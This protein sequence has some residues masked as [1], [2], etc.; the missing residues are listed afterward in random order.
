M[1]FRNFI[2]YCAICG[3]WAAFL[4]WALAEV[5]GVFPP[6]ESKTDAVIRASVIGALV[7]L[8]VASTIGMLDA[9]LN[10]VGF[11]RL[12]RAGVCLGVGLVGGAAGACVG[13]ILE[14]MFTT[15]AGDATQMSTIM[16]VVGWVIVGVAVGASIGIYDLMRA[17]TSRQAFG[18]AR[19]KIQ[20]GIIGGAVGGVLGAVGLIFL[21]KG[22]GLLSDTNLLGKFDTGSLHSPRAIGLV[23]LGMCIGLLI[24]TAHVVL[25]EAWIKVEQGFKAGREMMLSK[26]ETTVGRA[27]GVDIALFGDMGV[28]KLHA[29]IVLQA[30]RYLLVDNGTPGGTFL[31]GERIT[32]P[33]PLKNGDLIQM[34]KSALRFGERRKH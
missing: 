13:Q 14:N 16:K 2:Y 4:A 22:F 25:K 27:E 23:I 28:E 9:L 20:N 32:G 8:L 10:S 30:G 29:K 21:N 1:T 5:M 24:G 17:S 12:M 11:A 34:G 19:R 26:P 15:D 6:Y 3:G 18:M 31:N 33:T 7:G